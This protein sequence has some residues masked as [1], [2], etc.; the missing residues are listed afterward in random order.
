METSNGD[1]NIEQYLDTKG[2]IYKKR[3]EEYIT[4]CLFGCDDG[5]NERQEGHMNINPSK[6]CYNCFKCNKHGS[7]A[8]LLMDLDD[9]TAKKFEDRTYVG[10][11]TRKTNKEDLDKKAEECHNALSNEFR[12]SLHS[13]CL[14]DATIDKYKLGFGDFYGKPHLV[15][16]IPNGDGNVG[17]LKLR[18]LS[19]N[20]EHKYSNYPQG[21]SQVKLFGG[22]EL[23]DMRYEHAILCE[24]ELDCLVARQN[25]KIPFTVSGTGGAATFK[26]EWL[27]YFQFVNRVYLCLD[28]D[29]AGAKGADTIR[30]KFMARYP[31]MRIFNMVIPSEFGKDITDFVRKGGNLSNLFES[32]ELVAGAE[33]IDVSEFKEMTL[34][35]LADILDSTIKFNWVNK[36]IIFLCMLT[37]YTEEDQLALALNAPSATGKSWM[38]NEVAKYFPKGTVL[39]FASATPNSLKY[40]TQKTDPVTGKQYVDYERKIILFI[41]QPN[42]KVQENI[43]PLISHDAKEIVFKTTETVKSKFQ[44]RDIVM[45]GFSSMVFCSARHKTDEQEATRMIMLSPEASTEAIRAGTMLASK[46]AANPNKYKE[47]IE[48]DAGRISLKRRVEYIRDL[49]INSVIIPNEDEVLARFYEQVD[50]PRSRHQR[51]VAHLYSLIKA[52]TMLNAPFRMQGDN[53]VATQRDIDD[54]FKLWARISSSQVLGVSPFLEQFYN[55][56][57]LDTY[58]AKLQQDPLSEGITRNEVSMAYKRLVGSPLNQDSFRRD[59]LPTLADA[60]MLSETRD[61]NDKKTKIIVPLYGLD[62]PEIT[63]VKKEEYMW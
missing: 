7:I 48:N 31:D 17:H 23:L 11:K 42:Q 19:S 13:R 41:E 9:Y 38:T 25:E 34:D 30:E 51:D 58:K 59:F 39:I 4:H 10:K 53:L 15:I 14:L 26:D 60:G 61:E 37:A 56:Y 36:C 5:K 27:D 22:K 63:E 18:A 2:V 12:E 43:R 35:E 24:G 62:N 3:G 1:F 29:E 20:P 55:N 44:A 45:R 8:S 46:R 6:N 32:A 57:I 49:H 47:T 21:Q 28:N 52:V 54:G 33:E 40:A 50:K 16:P